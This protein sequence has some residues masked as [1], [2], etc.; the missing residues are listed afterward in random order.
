MVVVV[1]A[2]INVQ[3]LEE[4]GIDLLNGELRYT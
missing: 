3:S 2:N 1:E 4:T